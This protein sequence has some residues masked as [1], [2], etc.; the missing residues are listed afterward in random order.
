MGKGAP[1]FSPLGVVL[2]K[3]GSSS[4]FSLSG[5]IFL[6]ATGDFVDLAASFASFSRR[7]ASLLAGVGRG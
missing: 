5:L 6:S 7:F 4:F 1:F 3:G 2:T